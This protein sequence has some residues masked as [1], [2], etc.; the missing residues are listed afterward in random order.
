MD[1]KVLQTNR[2]KKNMLALKQAGDIYIKKKEKLQ[3]TRSKYG[4]CPDDPTKLVFCSI[5]SPN[6]LSWSNLPLNKICHFFFFTYKLSLNFKFREMIADIIFYMLK[7]TDLSLL[8]FVQ[9]CISNVYLS[10]MS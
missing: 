10:L 8:C 9:F 2:N 6:Y 1:T 3:I 7:F 4:Q 5:Y